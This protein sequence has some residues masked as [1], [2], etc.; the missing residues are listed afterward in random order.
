M[1]LLCYVDAQG[2]ARKFHSTMLP[3]YNVL[4]FAILHSVPCSSLSR[5][6][7]HVNKIWMPQSE[8]SRLHLAMFHSAMFPLYDIAFSLLFVPSQSPVTPARRLITQ[9]EASRFPFALSPFC[10]VVFCPVAF[11][12]V[13]FCPV[14]FLPIL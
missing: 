6:G 12:S 14:V 9:S 11:C 10:P 4:P 5:R 13:A 2:E 3:S 8:A 7:P 1:Q